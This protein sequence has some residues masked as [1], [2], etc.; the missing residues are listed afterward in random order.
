MGTSGGVS[1]GAGGVA[2]DLVIGLRVSGYLMP[3][4]QMTDRLRGIFVTF[5]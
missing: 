4:A 1:D 5:R 3:L 2:R